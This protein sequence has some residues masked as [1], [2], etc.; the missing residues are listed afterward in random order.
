MRLLL[1]SK[2]RGSSAMIRILGTLEE[3]AAR[4]ARLRNSSR[5]CSC[6]LLRMYGHACLDGHVRMG[7]EESSEFMCDEI[8]TWPEWRKRV[9]REGVV[10]DRGGRLQ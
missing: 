10:E 2:G 4:K 6:G 7:I 8:R 5:T 1:S 3:E 9:F